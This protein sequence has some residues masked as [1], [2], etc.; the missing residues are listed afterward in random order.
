MLAVGRNECMLAH[1][2]E[3]AVFGLALWATVF[4]F[5]LSVFSI[6]QVRSALSSQS[7]RLSVPL[8]AILASIPFALLAMLAVFSADPGISRPT[9]WS[10]AALAWSA[11]IMGCIGLGLL[12]SRRKQ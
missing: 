12:L 7:S 6:W 10:M 1:G 3:T 9:V 2:L 11:L 8:V 5:A 4:V